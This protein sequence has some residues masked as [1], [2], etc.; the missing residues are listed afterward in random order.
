MFKIIFILVLNSYHGSINTDLHFKSLAQCEAAKQ[1]ILKEAD[2]KLNTIK[3]TCLEMQ[4]PIK[5]TKCKIIND[6]SYKNHNGKGW[7]NAQN[8]DY[9]PYPTSL[10]CVEE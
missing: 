7:H 9:Y 5:K 1:Q 2:T 3:A 6:F 8:M 4:V 10:E